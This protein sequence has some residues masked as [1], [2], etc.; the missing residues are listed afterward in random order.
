MSL[1]INSCLLLL[2]EHHL[3][4]SSAIQGDPATVMTDI[5]FDSRQ[6]KEN[7]IFFC[8]GDR[9]RP[10]FLTMAREQG[11][12][13]YVAEKPLVEGSGLN[14]LIVR[15]VTK[16]MAILAAAFYDYPQD[17]LNTL[18][19]TGTKGK[20]TAAYFAHAILD[21]QIPQRVALFSTIERVMGTKPEDTIPAK[22]S[23]PESIDLFSEMNQASVNDLTDL[24]MEVSSQ[25]YLRNRVFGLTYDVGLFLNISPD[26]IGENEHPNYANYLHNKIQLIMNSRKVVLNAQ[27]QDWDMVLKSAQVSTDE[28]SIFIFANKD[29]LS[30]HPETELDFYYL[31]NEDLINGVKFTLKASSQK[32]KL[33]DIEGDYEISMPGVFNVVDA[34]GAIISATLLGANR[35]EAYLGIKDVRVPGRLEVVDLKNHGTGIVDFAHNKLSLS[36]TLNFIKTK[37]PQAKIGV[38]TGSAGEKGINRRADMG[39]VLNTMADRVYLTTD[40]PDFEEASDIAKEMSSC[41][42]NENVKVQFIEDRA[43]AIKQA[44]RDSG[45]NDVVLIAGKG[46]D[47]YMIIRG[48][49]LPYE[50]DKELALKSAEELG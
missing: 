44:V 48:Q 50:G 36:A 24:V 38:V 3:L 14:A 26:H 35:H 41:I 16:A 19:I 25:A 27:T 45:S 10:A 42:V 17:D 32:G 47:K 40:D 39:E 8:K 30:D 5:S 46:A 34:V 49:R 33:L 6:V 1:T 20:T 11:A 21:K 29:Y 23:T 2:K 18:A 12:I 9:F 22:L 28:D 13:T 43:E 4:K 15:N 31:V 7:C 37:F